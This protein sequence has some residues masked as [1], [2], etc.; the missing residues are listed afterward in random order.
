MS[1]TTETVYAQV[2]EKIRQDILSGCFEPGARIKTVT[3]G[4]R[5]GVSQMPI[6][7]ALQQLQGEGLVTIVPNRG[8]RV[9]AVDGAF[10][11]NIYDIR[12]ALEAMMVRRAVETSSAGDL[13][14]LYAA[15]ARYEEAV[16]AGNIPAAIAAN[17]ELHDGTYRLASNPEAVEVIAR[18]SELLESLRRR[19][20]F[21]PARM[22]EIV[23]EHRQLL[24]AFEQK[25]VAVAVAVATGHCERA[26]RD[27][28]AQGGL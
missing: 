5:Y 19:Y 17:R 21:G 3:L 11:R 18:H 9:R 10:I 6:R 1:T 28:I 14:P 16:Q 15:E 27:L 25:D 2:R 7:E 24:R 12:A 13:A 26:K 4:A 8:A 20:G 23:I 22:P